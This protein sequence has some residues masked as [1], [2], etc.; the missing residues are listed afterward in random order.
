[1]VKKCMIVSIVVI[2]AMFALTVIAQDLPFEHE[3]FDAVV[4][5]TAT[6]AAMLRQKGVD[7]YFLRLPSGGVVQTLEG[8]FFPRARF[9]SVLEEEVDATFVHFADYPELEG[10]VSRDGSHVD[11]SK[12][13]EFT[14]QLGDV[15]ARNRLQPRID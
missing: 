8:A 10:F 5:Y 3:S 2:M 4:N 13:V 6:I 1:M 12:I 14:R 7:L 15:L 9:W 11:S